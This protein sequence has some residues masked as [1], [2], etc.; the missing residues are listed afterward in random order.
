MPA[1]PAFAATAAV[2][3]LL[4]LLVEM[5]VL[6]GLFATTDLTSGQWLVCAAVGSTI[7]IAGE[8]VKGALRSRARRARRNTEVP[9]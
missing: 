9:A 5:D 8:L 3:G 1:A 2:V 4:V 7:L 6:H